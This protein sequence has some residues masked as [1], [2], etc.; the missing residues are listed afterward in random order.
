MEIVDVS[1]M[2]IFDEVGDYGQNSNLTV[3]SNSTLGNDNYLVLPF[4]VTI[5]LLLTKPF[6]PLKETLQRPFPGKNVYR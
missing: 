1:C 3:F 5:V 4:K 6:F 2:F